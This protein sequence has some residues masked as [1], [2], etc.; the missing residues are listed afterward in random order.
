MKPSGEELMTVAEVAGEL[1]CSR[2]HVYRIIRG[3]V[4]GLSPLA[5]LS[6]GRRVLVRRSRLERW[7]AEN[8]RCAGSAMLAASP[9]VDAG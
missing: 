7:K 1:R 6:L 9:E 5:A 2:P 8:E 3:E 4:E